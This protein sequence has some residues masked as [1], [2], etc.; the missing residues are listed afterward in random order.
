MI[1]LDMEATFLDAG[2]EVIGP[3]ATVLAAMDAVRNEEPS[4]AILDIRLGSETTES[5][6]DLLTEQ[7]VPFLFYSGQALPDDMKRKRGGA[8]VVAK[9]GER[10]LQRLACRR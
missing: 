8:V 6:G 3:C 10:K 2:A 9:P 5:I 7:G 4:L 1:A